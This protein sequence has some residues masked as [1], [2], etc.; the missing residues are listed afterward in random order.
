MTCHMAREAMLTADQTDL[1]GQTDSPL[2][3]H[4]RTCAR[5]R[6][7][8]ERLLRSHQEL[9]AY[10]A[11]P[12]HRGSVDVAR[13]ALQAAA[14]RPRVAGRLRRALPLAA[15][16]VIAGVLVSRRRP[17]SDQLTTPVSRFTS[18]AFSVTAPPGRNLVVLEQSDN[19]DI[20]VVWF[21]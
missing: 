19:P 7:A 2:G 3:R 11:T 10:L 15:A 6:A 14:H 16:A 17:S 1:D 5:C 9:A 21:Y 13:R 12:T 20:V 4:L 8:A 18:A